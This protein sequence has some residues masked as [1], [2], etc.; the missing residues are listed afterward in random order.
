M[1]SGDVVTLIEEIKFDKDPEKSKFFQ[2]DGALVMI[3]SH[4]CARA[5]LRWCQYALDKG[6]NVNGDWTP[7]K[8]PWEMPFLTPLTCAVIGASSE[9]VRLL[10][11][12]GANLD[13]EF[14]FERST[15]L[16][17]AINKGYCGIVALLLE[18]GA[19]PR[20]KVDDPYI[21][22]A[23]NVST[24]MVE[25]FLDHGVSASDIDPRVWTSEIGAMVQRRKECK[26]AARLV[27]QVLRKRYRVPVLGFPGGYKLP[28]EIANQ[29]ARYVWSFRTRGA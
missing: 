5:N 23:A 22:Q 16:Q 18:L 29:I 25:L 1:N 8:Q 14:G 27:Y 3:L 10:C 13:A 9:C 15:A 12:R 21:T 11:K 17:M 4:A 6:A 19:D 20:G 7:T 28:K 24:Q 2:V 26:T